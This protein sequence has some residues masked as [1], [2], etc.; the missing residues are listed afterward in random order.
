MTKVLIIGSGLGG[1]VLAKELRQKDASCQLIMITQD[2]GEYYTKPSLSHV[3][4]AAKAPEDLVMKQA[5]EMAN[6]E[7]EDFD[8]CDSYGH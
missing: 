3:Y 2:N 5:E 6:L 4:A 1:Y 7:Y 8:W